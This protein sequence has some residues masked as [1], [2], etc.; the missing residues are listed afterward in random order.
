[1]VQRILIIEDDARLG[2]M[3]S[4]YLGAAGFRVS[5]LGEGRA[6]LELLAHEPFDALVLDLTLPDMD[7]IEVCRSLREHA[8]TPVLML[9]ARGDAM[10]RVVGLEIGADDYLPKPIEPR[11]LLVG[12]SG[13]ILLM[14]FPR[15][16][17]S[18]LAPRRY[19]SVRTGVAA[20]TTAARTRV[21]TP[22]IIAP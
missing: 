17:P 3:L 11:E 1:M 13:A 9:T 12:S 19:Q 22:S 6:G 4:E 8:D 5:V 10:D 20:I 2:E 14:K 15:F 18:S 16:S 21:S 7:G